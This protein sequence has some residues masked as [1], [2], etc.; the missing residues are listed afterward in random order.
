MKIG[1]KIKKLRREK[2]MTQ[3]QLAEKLGLSP[4]AISA[5]ER[6]ANNPMMD[7]LSMMSKLFEVPITEFY[8]SMH[9]DN[10]DVVEL[11]EDFRD[12]VDKRYDYDI[13]E[14]IT[15]RERNTITEIKEHRYPYIEEPISAGLLEL[16]DSVVT[17][18][19]I[20]IPNVMMGKHAYNNNITMMRVNGESMNKVIPHGS[21]I[22]VKRTNIENIKDGDIVVFNYDQDY[23]I[24]RIYRSG[25]KMIFRPDSTDFSF[26]DTIV[27]INEQLKIVGKV[28]VYIVELD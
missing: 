14:P 25:S 17:K 9:V 12:M 10:Y 15:I 19:T 5:W 3:K 20:N 27:T 11:I 22:A 28:V 1:E 4:T 8:E 24:K 21:L 6:N 18:K 2:G 26:T 16:M 23:S 7:S 13:A